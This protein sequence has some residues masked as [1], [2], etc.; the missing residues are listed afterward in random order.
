MMLSNYYQS[1]IAY[2][3]AALVDVCKQ[4]NRLPA[5]FH[6]NF[7]TV[8]LISALGLTATQ[9]QSA[10]AQVKIM[11]MGD[12]ITVGVDYLTQT[13]GGYRD[14]LYHDLTAAGLSFTFVG[15][16]N[17]SPTSTLT[18]AGDSYHNGYGG[19]HIQDLNNNLDGVANPICGGDSNQ[20]GYFLTGGHG[21]GRAAVTPDIILLHIGTNDLL[22]GS[23]T[24]DQDLL[25]LVTHIH[26]LSPNSIILIAGVIPINSSG[27][28]AS[29]NAYNSYIKNHLVPSLY[30]LRYVEQNASFLNPDGTVD[31]SLLGADL[32]HPNRFGYPILAQNWASAIELLEGTK[33][34]TYNLTVANGIGS[35]TYPA[36]SIITLAANA[37]AAGTQFASW[38]PGI[39]AISNPFSS[40]ALLKMPEAPT[41]L[42]ANY[43][44]SGSPVIPD[45]TYQIVSYFSNLAV[46]A[47]GAVN[48]SQ[49]QQ[50]AYNSS[51]SQKWD[52]VN[53][54]GN[55]VSLK[56]S[57]T[58][59]ALEVPSANVTTLGANVD[60]ASYVG[61]TNQK[62]AVLSALG[63]TQ[64]QNVASG[65]VLNI[66][67]YSA[68]PGAP[69]LQYSAGLSNDQWDFFPVTGNQA[70]YILTVTDGAG[71]GNY[72]P[73]TS[74][75]V[76][77]N[78]APAGYT[79]S[80]WTGATAGMANTAAASTTIFT[81]A[82]DA[83]ITANYTAP[84][85]TYA[86]SV[87]NG[88]GSGAYAPGTVVTITANAPS[89]G[90]QFSGWN[91]SSTT[92]TSANSTTTTLTMP[93]A[94]TTVAA[95]YTA[96]P[97]G[98]GGTASS[99]VSVQFVGGGA[100][101]LHGNSFD[102]T[103]GADSYSAGNWNP[104]LAT[105]NTTAT[106]SLTI[107]S[108]L[109][110][111]TGAASSI[112]FQLTSSG[113]YYTGAGSGFTSTP[114]YPGY[115][116][117][118][119][120]S[121][122]A[123]LYAGF[124]YAGYSDHN[125][126]TLTV[127]GLNST[128]SYSLL[129]YLTPFEGFG[130]NQ[131]ATVALTAGVAYYVD[132]D[133]KAGTYEKSAS[134]SASSPAV[135]NYVEFDN[136]TGSASQTITLTDTSSMV[137]IS[138]FQIVDGGGTAVTSTYALSVSNGSGSGAYAPGTVVTIT[139]N[140]PSGGY[141]FSGWNCSSTTL[142]SA[143]STTTTLTM[144]AAATTVAATY[145]A[146]PAGGGGTASSIVSVQFVGGGA[147]PLHGN[148]FDYTAGADSYSAGNW[149]PRLATGNTTATQSLT[150]SSG[151][152]DS[153]GA[154]SSI[155]FQ[156][157]SSGAYYTGAGSGFTSTPPY[158]GYPGKASGS[159]DAFLYA[160]FAYAGYSDH[161]PVTLTVNGL[162]S[163]HSYSLLVYLTPFE[164]F[165][166]NQSA[167]VALTAG[168]AYY[169][170]T[171]GKAGTYEKS[172]ST[173]ASSP[174]VGNYVEFDN[175]T[176]SA[177]QT[178]T[179]TDT[180]SMVGISGFQ[181]VDMSATTTTA[182][183]APTPSSTVPA[184]Y[185]L[186]FDDEFT[187]FSISDV[188]GA[189]A[190]WYS[191]T[192]QCCMYDTSNPSTPTYKAGITSPAGENPFSLV[193]GGGLDIRLQKTN[194]TWYSGVIATVDGTGHGFSQQYGYFEMKAK[195]P[196]SIG[197]WPAFWL[198]NSAA[199]SS[200]ANTGEIDVVE[201]YMQFPTYTNIT[202][203]DWTQPASTPAY[204]QSQVADL[205][206]GFH[207]FGMLWTA[208]TMTFYCDGAVLFTTPTPTIMNQPYYP[209]I[210]LGLGGG[211]PTNQ[212]PAQ[213]DMVIQ[214]MRVYSA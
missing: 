5:K 169:V 33:P 97:A 138:G 146:I 79:F 141:Q 55:T 23:T 91:C 37:P 139:A 109:T 193:S 145:T 135:G 52:L 119:S 166:N 45:G 81:S 8:S 129:V 112:G 192:V 64:I 25:D 54:G 124:A 82:A 173:S 133:G 77:A 162:N 148:S 100:A 12:S 83:T 57:G 121:G 84:S 210:D 134:T 36:G 50:Q 188:N 184:G 185:H 142:T 108:G 161:N 59:E 118:A 92:L 29:V 27:F 28:T 56:L 131:S 140:A 38:T 200:G 86:L 170:D 104:R 11:P 183:T 24:I 1:F 102:Y 69:L 174:A 158:P 209:I 16:T 163:T 178:I 103:A 179:L 4:T 114:P 70:S 26:A 177:S 66:Q 68:S 105:G 19:W 89:G 157:T 125:P 2:F 96:I 150:I 189:S 44:A 47:S 199:L 43:S 136:L 78:P 113:A 194:G 127:N 153:T 206:N 22:Q 10:T 212:T 128:H 30:Y 72:V 204:H 49:V 67:G 172:A 15:T 61:S 205:S 214:Y 155:G 9:P 132:T 75:A 167:T 80:G 198:L 21:T 191:H 41:S 76:A 130:N 171:D 13:V 211:W 122:D 176:G 46:T 151:L 98:G 165:G 207:I 156:L 149:N 65:L 71:G 195:F 190:S 154:A 53:L 17:T 40:L 90:Y 42:T 106:Q 63:T 164:G 137:G 126:V 123:F 31:G 99:I 160:G 208:T 152:T 93:A 74:V 85:S 32:V 6:Y 62:W 144:P 159:G 147:A 73:G 202:L 175:L 51:A 110:D 111:S 213:S 197:A 201:S 196:A 58:L 101:P 88:S 35:G 20:G 180:S 107:S 116:G 143:N 34:T 168:V 182:S 186:T 115:P 117:K 14:P 60:V 95:T 87:S 39:T 7:L 94:A 203:H 120:G 3:R 187:S 181:I 18:A 48:G